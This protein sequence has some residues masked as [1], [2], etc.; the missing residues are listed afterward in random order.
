MRN[1][2]TT[3]SR[4]AVA[5]LSSALVVTGC[6][7]SGEGDQD[8]DASSMSKEEIYTP[9]IVGVEGDP[10]E[11]VEGGTL[12][13]A[14]YSEARSLDPTTTIPNGATGGN[15]LAAVYDTLMRY[16]RESDTFVPQLA[17]SLESEDGRTWTLTL[18]EG[19]T[20]SDGTPLDSAAV[21]GSIGYYMEN[22]GFNTLLL[23]SSIQDMKPVDD[24]TV[25]FTLNQ[26][27]PGFPQVL[28]SGAGMIVAPAAIKNGKE[29]FEPIGAG[30]FTLASYKPAEELVLDRRDD[31]WGGTP[32]LEQLRFVWLGSDDAKM[33]AL[34]SGS[35]DVANIRAAKAVEDA[36]KDGWAGVMSPSGMGSML[37]IN[38]RED[39]PGADPRVREAI[40][41]AID[42]EQYLERSAGGAGIPSRSIYSA[43]MPYYEDIE[44]IE[45]DPERATELVEEAK[46]DGVDTTLTYIGQSDQASQNAAVAVEAQLE[47][48]GFDV[49]LELL[50]DITEQTNRIYVTHDFDLAVASL[51]LGP[52][53][54]ANLFT[55]L[56]SQSPQ[57]PSGYA[58]EEMDTLLGQL[59]AASDDERSDILTAINEQWQADYPGVA[60]AAGAF[61]LP[62]QDEVHGIVPSHDDIMLFAEAWKAED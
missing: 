29:G 16:D 38:N 53:P 30:P 7:S 50:N 32:H 18:R 36:R 39:Q 24:R 15:A 33:D 5:L 1:R 45:Q 48:V 27:W 31:Y 56:S 57:N 12:T 6:A 37:W 34:D 14:D 40:N 47:A 11:P 43:A 26:P 2:T 28:A 4:V 60:L 10:G 59:Q 3:R 46:A 41:L 51:S 19:V 20:F 44:T 49:E 42:P 8:D 22:F 13:V 55:G 58:S 35:V 9:G 62:W 54:F 23:A 61:F 17:E 52:N 25:E 21:L